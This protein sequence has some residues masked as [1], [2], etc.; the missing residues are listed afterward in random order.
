[1]LHFAMKW[2]LIHEQRIASSFCKSK[3]LFQISYFFCLHHQTLCRYVNYYNDRTIL[4]KLAKHEEEDC[5]VCH[6]E[7]AKSKTLKLN[8]TKMLQKEIIPSNQCWICNLTFEDGQSQVEHFLDEHEC[9]FCSYE[10][11]VDLASKKKHFSEKHKMCEHCGEA[12]YKPLNLRDHIE[13]KHKTDKK[14]VAVATSNEQSNSRPT[15]DQTKNIPRSRRRQRKD[16][17][18]Q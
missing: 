12:F 2:N 1:M 11:F 18:L 9:Q 14:A 17:S 16:C 3:L 5:D 6:K 8:R 15:S 4:Q 7:E 13:E 10:F